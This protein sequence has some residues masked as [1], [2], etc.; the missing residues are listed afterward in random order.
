[1]I[2][3]Q[4]L[5]WIQKLDL[6]YLDFHRYLYCFALEVSNDSHTSMQEGEL[7][8]STRDPRRHLSGLLGSDF[9]IRRSCTN[10]SLCVC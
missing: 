6:E 3:S 4:T 9:H 2:K 5:D 1:M 8:E 7:S 10:V